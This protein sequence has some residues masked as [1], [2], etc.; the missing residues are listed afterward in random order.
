MFNVF[1]LEEKIP[2]AFMGISRLLGRGYWIIEYI[3]FH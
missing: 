2:I 3:T 1:H